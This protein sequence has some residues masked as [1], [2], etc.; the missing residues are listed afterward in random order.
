MKG[1]EIKINKT[2]C[3]GY[4]AC[5]ILHT[6]LRMFWHHSVRRTSNQQRWGI[7]PFFFFRKRMEKL[8]H[9]KWSEDSEAEHDRTETW[10]MEQTYRQSES[11][12]RGKT[13]FLELGQHLFCSVKIKNRLGTAEAGW[14]WNNVFQSLFFANPCSC[15]CIFNI[16]EY[17]RWCRTLQFGIL[18]GYTAK[19]TP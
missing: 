7:S 4:S 5:C 10:Q 14:P 11:G 12:V 9:W 15:F 19:Y 17:K 2:L 1:G 16:K 3:G 18:R 8:V 13:L 6:L